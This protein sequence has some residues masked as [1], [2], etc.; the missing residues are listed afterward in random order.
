MEQEEWREI[1][2]FEGRY[3]VSNLGQVRSM[4][5]D[6]NNHTGVI[7][8]KGKILNQRY[9]HKGYKVVDLVDCEHK[10]K[11]R[12]VH[13]LLAQAF[14]P[15]PENKPQIN[16]IDGIKDHNVLENLEW[17]TN[18]EN[19]IHAYATGLNVRSDKAGRLKK[20][21]LQIDKDTNEVIKRFDS[22]LEAE[23]EFGSYST[24][25]RCCIG[26]SHTAYGYK[27][28]YEENYEPQKCN[29]DECSNNV[30][31]RGFC[32]KHYLRFMK[33]GDVHTTK[34]VAHGKEYYQYKD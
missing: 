19:Q 26:A 32:H 23:K 31:A 24:I 3:E 12:L 5:R 2:E 8:L 17:V 10:H 30:W 20:A 34:T 9:N 4:P 22:F 33:Y 14:I 21:I 29:V 6:V 18:G 16:H 15:N 28:K 27:W 11:Y 13:R 25:R 7:H 1:P